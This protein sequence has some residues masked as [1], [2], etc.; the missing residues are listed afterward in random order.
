MSD[1][2][3]SRR[4]ALDILAAALRAVDARALVADHLRAH[5]VEGPVT[6][7]A[8]GKAAGAMTRGALDVLGDRVRGGLVVVPDG[9]PAD[10]APLEVLRA[11]HPVPDE[12]SLRAGERLLEVAAALGPGDTVV[13]LWS[14]GGSALA[15]APIPGITLDDLRRETTALLRA[16]APIEVINRRRAEL[17][18]LKGGGLARASRARFV[19]LVLSDVAGDDP[20]VVASGPAVLPGDGTAVVGRLADVVRA[21]R[22]E[23]F[24]LRYVPVVL[25][26]EVKG[27]ARDV[28]L[29]LAGA[30]RSMPTGG[31]PMA[32]ILA[33]EPTVTVRGAGRGG[34]MQVVALTAALELEGSRA[35]VLCAGTDGRDGPTEAAGAVIDGGTAA[36]IRAAGLDPRALLDEDDSHRALAVAGD[37]LVTGPTGTNVRDLVVALLR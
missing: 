22:S 31:P 6:V 11:A 3:L 5:P 36:R 37:L 15:E 34:R 25:D 23:A 13:G 9:A 2:V 26:P 28:G 33:G 16:G 18:R 20:A 30:I 17:S 8:L 35:V 27:E 1:P 19:N 29:R 32:L 10:V 21:A 12:R 24:A 7:L 4:D 14:G